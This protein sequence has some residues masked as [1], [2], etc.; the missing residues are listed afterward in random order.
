MKAHEIKKTLALKFCPGFI[1]ASLRDHSVA[2]STQVFNVRVQQTP[3][4]F[5]QIEKYLDPSVKKEGVQRCSPGCF[6]TKERDYWALSRA[7]PSHFKKP[8]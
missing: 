5:V 6:E 8:E 7:P 1:Q 3:S 4:E 2:V